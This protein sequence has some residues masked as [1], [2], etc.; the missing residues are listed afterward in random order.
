M[1]YL[2]RDKYTTSTGQF[3]SRSLGCS[4]NS[5]TALLVQLFVGFMVSGLMHSAGDAMV[6]IQHLWASLPFFLAQPVAITLETAVIGIARQ[7]G[8]TRSNIWIRLVGY[9]WVFLWFSISVPWLINWA[10][11]AGLGH[12]E[13]LPISPIRSTIR[14]LQQFTG[15][16]I[17]SN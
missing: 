10:V 15:V 1:F 9:A 16:R 14:T 13:I 7:A 5:M 12:C 2:F 4:P 8:Y 3:C 11:S 17:L 6:G